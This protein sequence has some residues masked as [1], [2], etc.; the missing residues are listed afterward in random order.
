MSATRTVLRT[1][2]RLRADHDAGDYPTDTQY[3]LYLHSA[4]HRA[5][6]DLIGAGWQP[7]L[8]SVNVSATGVQA[9]SLGLTADVYGIHGVYYVNGSRYEPLNRLNEQD[10]AS[11]MGS[12]SNSR[13]RYYSLTVSPSAG[14]AIELLPPPASG[15]YRVEYIVDFPGFTSDS[16]KWYGPAMSQEL[17]ALDA[18]RQ[19]VLKEGRHEDARALEAEYQEYLVRVTQ[20]AANYDMRNPPVMR[21]VYAGQARDD[22]DFDVE[23]Y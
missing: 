18:A 6:A 20:H 14:P 7:T 4:A 19:A 17:L 16:D 3:N 23:T 22:F 8:S 1:L 11:L 13:A 9:Y 2:A 21:D 10:R 12:A 15:T 5:W